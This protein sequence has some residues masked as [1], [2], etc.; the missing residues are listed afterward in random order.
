M[1]EFEKILYSKEQIAE[2]VLALGRQITQDYHSTEDL[3]VLGLLKGAAIFLADLIR[4]IELPLEYDFIKVSS[5]GNASYPG[6]LTIK[7]EADISV[8]GRHVLI[9]EDIVD[10]GHTLAYVLNYLK[11]KGPL[12]LR[13]CCLL[14]KLPRR[15]VK[16][17]MDYV[18]FTVKEDYFLVGYGLDY[19]GR[20]RNLP[21]VAA[22]KPQLVR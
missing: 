13:T 18:G 4:A 14:D 17:K 8:G 10:T 1:K 5:Y 2:R 11:R 21:Y 20:Y 22:L 15:K 7:H 6:E 16:V 3:L 12:S 19:A 9:V